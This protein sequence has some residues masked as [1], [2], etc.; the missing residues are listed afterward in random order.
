MN[1]IK[2]LIVDDD[3]DNRLVL[4][5]ICKKLDGFT[6]QEATNG[7]EAIETVEA[8]SPDIVLMDIMMPEMDGYEASKIIQKMYPNTTIIAI[9]ASN[10][11]NIQARMY[12]VGINIYINKPVDRSLIRY[13]LQSLASTLRKK[14]GITEALS[15]KDALN[16]FNSD[17]RAFKTIFDISNT[18]AIMDFGMWLFDQY[19]D[20]TVTGSQRYDQVLEVL[21]K[22]M[23]HAHQNDEAVTLII[24]E[25]HD[26][27]YIN[28][29]FNNSVC[30]NPEMTPMMQQLGESFIV[31]DQ[32]LS[33]KLS[34]AYENVEQQMMQVN[35]IEEKTVTEIPTKTLEQ[36]VMTEEIETKETRVVNSSETEILRQSFVNKTSA[37][38]YVSE[39]G[40]DVFEEIM[41]LASVDEE[42][43]SQLI[44]IET[45][46][47]I[48][49]LTYF[50]DVVF[51]AYIRVINNLFEFNG[52]AYALS[53]L[54]V[55]FN[56]HVED[57]VADETKLKTL[58]MLLEHLGEDLR[59][60]KE[61]IFETQ[62]T[63]DIH[64][65]DSSFFSS[66]MQIESIVGDKSLSTDD[67]DDIEFF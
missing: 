67:D 41:E 65:L 17:I 12:D 38:D 16:P 15:T 64:Y 57:I 42:W 36:E 54:S 33:F 7:L 29:Q 2:L 61:H 1:T 50:T 10:D 39:L 6:I 66:C 3:E 18:A 45:E 32:T 24:E 43:Q 59:S 26:E 63:A 58:V 27:F 56:D 20:K 46:K 35:T 60:W 48:E 14:R 23:T 37:A 25:S 47:S 34:K 28:V 49:S 13:K 40:G 51:S 31:H 21:Y 44:I 62:S 8:W 52:L 4:N 19:H 55:F 11:V 5:A 30:I 9:T 22:L 53:S